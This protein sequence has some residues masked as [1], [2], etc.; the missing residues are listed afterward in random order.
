VALKIN[1]S[2]FCCYAI[3]CYGNFIIMNIIFLGT[4]GGI[5]HRSRLHWRH[6]VTRIE[7]RSHA[8]LLDAGADWLQQ[9]RKLHADAIILT[10][11]HPDHVGGLARGVPYPV[12]ATQATLHALANMPLQQQCEVEDERLFTI[13]PFRIT[14]YAVEHSLRAPAVGY[15]IQA[16]KHTIFY[17]GDVVQIYNRRDALHQVDL[18]IGDGASITRSIIRLH[19]GYRMGHT[20]IA[21]QIGWCAQEQIPH[22]IFTHCGSQLVRMGPEAAAR[23]AALGE[24]HRVRADV[25]YDGMQVKL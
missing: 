10:H 20:S 11:A 13:G 17:A 6:A 14:P 15:R 24:Q 3:R 23:V 7:F 21:Q 5:K 1:S 12:Y 8:L 16:G 9:M 19:D 2:S 25:A 22:A 4:R 18:Y